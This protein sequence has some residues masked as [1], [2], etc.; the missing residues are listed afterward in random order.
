M[1][2]ILSSERPDPRAAAPE[3]DIPAPLSAVCVRAMALDPAARYPSAEMFARAVL[4]ATGKPW[5]QKH[6]LLF[7][8]KSAPAVAPPAPEANDGPTEVMPQDRLPAA[9]PTPAPTLTGAPRPPS[10]PMPRPPPQPT[11]RMKR[12]VTGPAAE[13]LRRAATPHGPPSNAIDRLARQFEIAR[14]EVLAGETDAASA[15]APLGRKLGA[16]LL[17]AA[18]L[19]EAAGVLGEVLT[20]TDPHT[21]G[22]VLL[23]EQLA[24]VAERR[25]R[26][27]DAESPLRKALEVAEALPDAAAAARLRAAGASGSGIR[28]STRYS[29][30][31]SSPGKKTGGG[32]RKG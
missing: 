23:A 26:M 3:R 10:Q 12:P 27:D 29:A 16:A 19:D 21:I 9:R 15:W 11:V 1:A 5:S 28:P 13:A 32:H 24:H 30:P 22:Y 14:R 25:G 17:E 20:H 8:P 6:S 31:A 4:E 2:Q 18:R 7:V